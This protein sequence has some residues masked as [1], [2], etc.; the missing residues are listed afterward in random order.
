MFWPLGGVGVCGLACRGISVPET[1]LAITS[2]VANNQEVVER[3][4]VHGAIALFKE[5]Q[6]PCGFC[7]AGSAGVCTILRM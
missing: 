2:I 6:G 1:W 7:V 4:G 3:Y 5:N